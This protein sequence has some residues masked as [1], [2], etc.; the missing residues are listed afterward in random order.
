[1][2]GGGDG[3]TNRLSVPPSNRPGHDLSPRY[4]RL[5]LRPFRRDRSARRDSGLVTLSAEA[6]VRGA[7]PAGAGVARGASARGPGGLGTVDQRARGVSESLVHR[8]LGL[9]SDHGAR[10]GSS[11]PT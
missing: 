4:K 9:L 10:A 3:L 2:A 8:G 1:M 5:R 6:G 7:I 11:P